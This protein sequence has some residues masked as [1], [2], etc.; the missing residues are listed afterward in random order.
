MSHPNRS[1]FC[2]N[3]Q[4]AQAT[5]SP[6]KDIKAQS[7]RP[8]QTSRKSQSKRTASMIRVARTTTFRNCCKTSARTSAKTGRMAEPQTRQTS[9]IS[10]RTVKLEHQQQRQALRTAVVLQTSST[11]NDVLSQ[12]HEQSL[13]S[14]ISFD[15]DEDGT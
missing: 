11:F 15:E 7:F 1:L 2:S 10:S 6:L 8:P 12:R 3:N 4:K 5:D 14:G 9:F 13:L